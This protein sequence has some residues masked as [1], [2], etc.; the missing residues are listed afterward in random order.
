M[1]HSGE[2]SDNFLLVES[3]RKPSQFQ[4]TQ[5]GDCWKDLLCHSLSAV[6]VSDHTRHRLFLA[7]VWFCSQWEMDGGELPDDCSR[8]GPAD[9]L[10]A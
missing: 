6:E 1:H 5:P 8:V 2:S 3:S 4:R 10:S 7:A 9:F